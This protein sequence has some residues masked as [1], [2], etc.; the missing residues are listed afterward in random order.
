M[1]RQ[2]SIQWSNSR[3]DANANTALT[4]TQLSDCQFQNAHDYKDRPVSDGNSAGVLHCKSHQMPRITWVLCYDCIQAQH[5]STV[6]N[7]ESK[8]CV[9]GGVG[10]RNK[11]VDD[12]WAVKFQK[13][14]SHILSPVSVFWGRNSFLEHGCVDPG[15]CGHMRTCRQTATC[16]LAPDELH[17]PDT[18]E[19]KA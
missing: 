19:L 2:C 3:R 7:T 9:C 6:P 18:D 14:I 4:L 8:V 1:G 13:S 16:F 17:T 5:N 12:K 15:T 10:N 11:P